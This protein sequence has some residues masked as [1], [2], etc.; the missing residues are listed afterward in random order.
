MVLGAVDRLH[1]VRRHRHV[2][3]RQHP[4]GAELRHLHGVS[5]RRVALAI[6]AGAQGQHQGD[7]RQ[8]QQAHGHPSPRTSSLTRQRRDRTSELVRRRG[9]SGGC[10]VR[11][12]ERAAR[13]RLRQ[14]PDGVGAGVM[15]D[16]QSSHAVSLREE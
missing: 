14:G 15:H 13:D 16:Q 4:T 11:V 5:V 2:L 10:R 8:E 6:A 3:R 9:L 7:D 1:G 12:G